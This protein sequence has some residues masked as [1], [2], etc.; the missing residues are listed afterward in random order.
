MKWY[1]FEKLLGRLRDEG[2]GRPAY[3]PLVMFKA[4]LLA[5]VLPYWLAKR[6]RLIAKRR[7]AVETIFAVL[8]HHM[9]LRRARYIGL[10]KTAAHLLLAALAF[11]MRRAAVLLGP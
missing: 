9:S 7:F 6:N 8:K 2:R 1:R 5:P 4:L 3:P 10:I 11:N